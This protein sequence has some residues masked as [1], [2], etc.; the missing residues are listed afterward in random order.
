MGVVIITGIIVNSDRL[1]SEEFGQ[2]SFLEQNWLS[3]LFLVNFKYS[4]YTC[5]FFA[6]GTS[7]LS[8]LGYTGKDKDGK[9]NFDR[10]QAFNYREIEFGTCPRQVIN[11]WNI[12]VAHWLKNYIYIRIEKGDKKKQS[13]A[14]ILVFMTSAFWH[15]FMPS[16]YIFF[17]ALNLLLSS[18]RII[19]KNRAMFNFIPAFLRK[20][21]TFILTQFLIV[22][23]G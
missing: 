3:Y 9:N 12:Q 5:W 18:S 2:L 21:I 20:I 6:D 16:Y 15:G 4:G 22:Q 11:S 19:H 7:I 23:L 10:V 17:F 13:K 1:M 14:T 8:G